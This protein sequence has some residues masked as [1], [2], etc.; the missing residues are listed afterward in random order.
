[1]NSGVSFLIT[2]RLNQDPLE[3]LFSVIRSKGGHRSNSDPR[4]FRSA[5]TQT[6]VDNIRLT[7]E[8]S[9]CKADVD[10][11]L[12][13]LENITSKGSPTAVSENPY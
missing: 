9:N 12:F 7:A 8:S 2:S 3:N 11:F 13:S 1:M 6:M 5:I 4:E 10:T